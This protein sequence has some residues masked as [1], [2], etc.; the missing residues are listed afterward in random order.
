MDAK[1][2][3]RSADISLIIN[4]A[5]TCGTFNGYQLIA[6]V[7]NVVTKRTILTPF[8]DQARGW[9]RIKIASDIKPELRALHCVF[10]NAI[11]LPPWFRGFYLYLLHLLPS[12]F[13]RCTPCNTLLSSMHS[14]SSST[15]LLHD[16]SQSLPSFSASQVD[17]NGQSKPQYIPLI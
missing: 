15:L 7:D 16:L 4:V 13:A 10:D 8:Y 12:A 14:L 2:L 6:C 1:D 11:V 3:A 5:P 17:G 9:R